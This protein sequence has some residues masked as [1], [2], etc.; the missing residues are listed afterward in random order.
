MIWLKFS[1]DFNKLVEIRICSALR[2]QGVGRVIEV[3][4]LSCRVWDIGCGWVVPAFAGS[5]FSG[6]GGA[7]PEAVG[8]VYFHGA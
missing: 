8:G 2:R 7:E 1:W 4:G 3:W 6:R 5:R